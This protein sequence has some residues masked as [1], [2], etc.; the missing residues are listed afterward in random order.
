VARSAY[1][2]TVAVTVAPVLCPHTFPAAVAAW[3]SVGLHATFSE[4]PLKLGAAAEVVAGLV[5]LLAEEADDATAEVVP[6]P[7][8]LA[9]ALLLVVAGGGVELAV[10]PA[11]PVLQAASRPPPPTVNSAPTVR[12]LRRLIPRPG[13]LSV[14]GVP[15]FRVDEAR[16]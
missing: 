6:P 13:S 9:A 12:K 11:S 15:F 14:T 4:T 2:I 10:E 8:E 16:R 3:T 5:A 1:G 7:V